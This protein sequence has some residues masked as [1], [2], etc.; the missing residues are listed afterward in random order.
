VGM[1]E[2]CWAHAHAC[3]RECVK[4]VGVGGGSQS[5]AS[6]CACLPPNPSATSLELSERP[7]CAPH[8]GLGLQVR[9]PPG[10]AALAAA[11]GAHGQGGAAASAAPQPPRNAA[12]ASQVRPCRL[13]A[14]QGL[15]QQGV[16]QAEGARVRALAAC[17]YSSLQ[18]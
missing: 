4:G 16:A 2:G 7:A 13:H 12:A 18:V 8:D 1:C 6:Q 5:G 14:E 10:S 11:A 15:V 3:V 17:G 9:K